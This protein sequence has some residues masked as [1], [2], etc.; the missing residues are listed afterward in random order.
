M[1]SA[2]VDPANPY[3]PPKEVEP[4]PTGVEGGKIRYMYA[5]SYIFENPNWMTNIL[6]GCLCMIIPV[7]GPLLLLGYQFDIVENQHRSPGR[8]YPDFDFN[9]F[10]YYLVRGIW[11][12]L[13]SLILTFP[14][15]IVIYVILGICGALLG[16]AASAA[17]KDAAPVV[18]GVGMVFFFA[19][20]F[21]LI[22]LVNIIVQPFIIRA[23][24]SQDFGQSFKFSWAMDFIKRN[25]LEM[26][27]FQLFFMVTAVPLALLGLLMCI[28]GVYPMAAL[29]FLAQAS[30][31]L[32][33]YNLNLSRG[34][35]PIPLKEPQPQMI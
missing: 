28:I 18:F 32:Q 31:L 7:I 4:K 25:W 11:P 24:L 9:K 22:L 23:G 5:Y 16:V 3:Q 34:G 33:L 13:A 14:L 1:S 15:I 27:L 20:E 10:T 8:I 17:G 12:F 35:E 21:T 19:V 6:Y 29:I 26:L 2:P 30:M